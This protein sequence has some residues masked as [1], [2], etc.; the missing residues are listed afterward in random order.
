[1]IV[2]MAENAPN[3]EFHTPRSHW[4]ENLGTPRSEQGNVIPTTLNFGKDVIP[5]P[6][7]PLPS[8]NSNAIYDEIPVK[9][10]S[11]PRFIDYFYSYVVTSAKFLYHHYLS[12]PKELPAEIGKMLKFHYDDITII[13][14]AVLTLL[15]YKLKGYKERHQLLPI[16]SIFQKGT[17]DIDMTWS[18][19]VNPNIPSLQ[20]E[21]LSFTG[22]KMVELLNKSMN[23]S[24]FIKEVKP[25]INEILK[26]NCTLRVDVQ[27]RDH[28]DRYG[29][30]S[31]V[32]T[33][34][35][36][37]HPIKIG[38]LTLHD[39]FNSQRFNDYH[40]IIPDPKSIPVIFDPIYCINPVASNIYGVEVN[41]ILLD[42]FTSVSV[43]IRIPTLSRYVNQQLFAAGNLILDPAYKPT[44]KEK[45]YNHIRRVAYLLYLLHSYQSTANNKNNVR[46]IGILANPYAAKLLLFNM[47]YQKMNIIINLQQ[48]KNNK[49]KVIEQFNRAFLIIPDLYSTLYQQLQRLIEQERIAQQAEQLRQQVLF[50]QQ[51]MSSSQKPSIRRGGSTRRNK[52]R[53]TIKSVR[54]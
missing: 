47:V 18:I 15:D 5:K 29:S 19:P 44:L 4:S 38:D 32:F 37:D 8:M 41:T 31:I 34:I 33:F 48:S 1:M 46:K 39:A 40:Q 10:V 54:R 42:P 13:G 12:K 22:T 27:G 53:R 45:G 36:D 50:Q 11:D 6:N 2:K 20:P 51:R 26:K 23:Q 24:A 43:P 35:V 28:S 30:F 25:L 21:H 17:S 16:E 49:D 7:H 3:D 14:G 9:L 52:V